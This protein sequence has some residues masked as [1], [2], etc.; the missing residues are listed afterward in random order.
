MI[1]EINIRETS[2]P[3]RRFQGVKEG[4]LDAVEVSYNYNVSYN[5]CR[6]LCSPDFHDALNIDGALIGRQPVW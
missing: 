3:G 4:L 2:N 6:V 5:K 1:A